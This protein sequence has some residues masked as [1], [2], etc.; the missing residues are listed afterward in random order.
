MLDA[1]AVTCWELWDVTV[2][3]RCHAWS[4]SPLYHLSQQVL[5]VM[6]E[7]PGWGRIRIAPCTGGDL[8]YARG[9][10]PSPLGPIRIEWEKAGDDQLAV[11]V[12]LPGG[13]AGR[14]IS[15]GG[16]VRELRNGIQEFHT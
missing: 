5:G 4:A 2:E 7:E 11:R 12:D 8:E 6:S 9:V 13:M 1:G 14:F 10:V 15:P 16:Q 3:S